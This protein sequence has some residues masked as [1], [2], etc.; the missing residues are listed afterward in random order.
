M[1][2][3]QKLMEVLMKVLLTLTC[4]LAL[5]CLAMVST[6]VGADVPG[7][8]NIQGKLTDP[9]SGQP[10]ANGSYSVV[11]SIYDV[12]SSGTALWEETRSVD[13]TDGLF[14]ILLGQIDT[15][16]SSLFDNPQLWLGMK[17][18]DDPEMTP[19]Q[20]LTTSPYAFRTPASAAGGGWVDDGSVVRLETNTDSVGIGTVDPQARLHVEDSS[21]AAIWAISKTGTGAAAGVYA[22]SD[23]W[24]AV[25]GI[26]SNVNAAVMGRNDGSGPGIRGQNQAT[27]PAIVGHAATGNLLELYT[28]PGPTQRLLVDNSGN[29]EAAGTIHS[30]SGG[31]EFPDGTVQTTAADRD[32]VQ[33]AF[34]FVTYKSN[35]PTGLIAYGAINGLGNV[36]SA[37]TN[38]SC[39]WDGV[40]KRYEITISDENYYFQNYVT[41]VTP[42][43][44]FGTYATTNS[45]NYKLLVYMFQNVPH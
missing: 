39:T 18:G 34:S 19:R 4:G 40:N 42:I 6:A 17:V 7:M 25:L 13:V 14:S 16:P 10:V 38:V 41:I 5:L 22:Y 26:N 11:F 15:I 1:V 29:V 43:G 35:P 9:S 45:Y 23:S 2:N 37:T 12:P 8:I 20:R 21:G 24:H 36:Y 30:T 3:N 31:F 44:G 27:G 32:T 33:C 28:T